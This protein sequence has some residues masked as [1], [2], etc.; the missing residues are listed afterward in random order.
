MKIPEGFNNLFTVEAK[1]AK[2]LNVRVKMVLWVTKSSKASGDTATVS[3]SNVPPGTY[4][5]KI[6]GN[7]GE[8]VSEVNLKIT[9]FQKIKADSNGNFSYSYNTTAVPP[10]NFEVKVGDITKEITLRPE[11]IEEPSLVLP[12]ANFSSDVTEGYAPLT[13]QFTDLSENATGCKLGLWRRN[14]FNTT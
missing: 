12:V 2:N 9:A 7:A 4:K 11:E 8:G 14:Q 10:G 1:G 13:V 5:I 6:D 3:Q